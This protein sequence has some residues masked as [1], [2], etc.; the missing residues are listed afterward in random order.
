MSFLN[1][2]RNGIDRL[3]MLK[4]ETTYETLTV[5]FANS[6]LRDEECCVSR[7]GDEFK[8]ELS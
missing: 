1:I 5:S 6:F 3:S 2:I 4:E 7:A 8:A